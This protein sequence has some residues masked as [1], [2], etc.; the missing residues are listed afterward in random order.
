MGW[1]AVLE[2]MVGASVVAR[3]WAAYLA[4]FVETAGGH[5]PDEPAARPGGGGGGGGGGGAA[6]A[7]PRRN[8]RRAQRDGVRG[9]GA[10]GGD[11]L[12]PRRPLDARERGHRRD[13]ARRPAALRRRR[14]RHTVDTANLEPFAPHGAPGVL[15]AG[16]TVFFAF[17]GF[18]GVATLAEETAEPQRALPRGIL[19]SLGSV[20]RR[21]CRRR[22]RARRR[23]AVRCRRR[24]ARAPAL[25]RAEAERAV[26]VGRR[27]R[28]RRLRHPHRTHHL[29]RRR[30]RASS[31][32]GSRRLPPR[33]PRAGS[34]RT[35][36]PVAASV[37]TGGTA[38]LIAFVLPMS[39]LAHLTSIGAAFAFVS[40]CLAV[41]LRRYTDV[42]A[43]PD[44]AAAP[45]V[46]VV[47]ERLS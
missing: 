38:A 1:N 4:S 47:R 11:R 17:I 15:R 25:R 43:P 28:R 7:R 2:Y 14:V 3:A 35:A 27:R 18:D 34:T 6:T 33:T 12:R 5:L 21:L 20:D 16:G 23:G 31:S 45:S 44:A 42:D 22:D 26:G 36:T 24:H 39:V 32:D 13:Q 10:G 29:P 41:L 8:L 46:S 30:A 9:G 40:A 19:G 37:A